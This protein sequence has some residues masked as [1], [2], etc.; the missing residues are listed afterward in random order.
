MKPQKRFEQIAKRAAASLLQ[1]EAR[2][3]LAA[4]AAVRDAVAMVIAG[5]PETATRA[6]A[7]QAVR[8]AAQRILRAMITALEVVRR[9]ARSSAASQ[10]GEEVAA[11][12]A[13]TGTTVST[14]TFVATETAVED[15]AAVEAAAA[16]YTA[17]WLS[18]ALVAV[19]AWHAAGAKG[20]AA[21][22]I[23]KVAK[24][25]DYRLK[26]IVVTEATRARSDEHRAR[27]LALRKTNGDKPWIGKTFRRWDARLDRKV[28]SVCR[29]HDAEECPLDGT[30]S[31]GHEPGDVHPNCRCIATLVHFPEAMRI[32]T[33]KDAP[34]KSPRAA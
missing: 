1:T 33:T 29:A 6:E 24:D 17:S 5:L 4:R 13:I 27:L 2:G 11:V 10:V 31:K 19:A 21:S 22:S 26:R 23:A 3:I 30:F 9:S 15:I 28:C 8:S 14:G 16:G 32:D 25:V 18:V 12:E 34:R 20:S 7:S